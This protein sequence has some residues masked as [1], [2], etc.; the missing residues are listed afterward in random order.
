MG[1]VKVLVGKDGW[2]FLQN[3]TNRVIEQNNGSLKLTERELKKWLRI[4]ESRFAVL[5]NRGIKYYFLIAPNKESIY[6]EYLPDDYK[7]SDDRVVYQLINTCKPYNLPLYFPVDVLKL[8]KTEYQ[9]YPLAD[10]HWNGIGAFIA[11]EYVMNII[12]KDFTT[13]I[14]D[15]EEI[16]FADGETLLDLGSKLTPPQTSI[17]S[18]GVVKQPRAQIIYENNS[19]GYTKIALNKNTSLP[20]AIVFH[21]SFINSVIPFIIESFSKTYL[22]HSPCIDYD[23]LEKIKPDVV[24]S[25]MVER[26]LI[27]PPVDN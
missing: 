6:P 21:D 26:F 2:L 12:Q 20:T 7:I 13:K 9:M 23:L 17:F 25:E 14:L 16:Q 4:L 10:T 24:I 1:D 8:Y 27:K 11:Y 5:K 3:D 22:I 18:W 19:S 15:W